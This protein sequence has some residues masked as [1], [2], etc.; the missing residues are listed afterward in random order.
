MVRNSISLACTFL[1][2]IEIFN[3]CNYAKIPG[4]SHLLW[5]L[6]FLMRK[7]GDCQVARKDKYQ[8]IKG[9]YLKTRRQMKSAWMLHE[10]DREFQD[11]TDYMS[12]HERQ[13]Y[14]LV[15]YTESVIKLQVTL[16]Q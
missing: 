4:L 11:E 3:I 9:D 13:G 14:N 2:N 1:V 7:I 15:N 5:D 12:L 16:S 6:D 10:L 8:I